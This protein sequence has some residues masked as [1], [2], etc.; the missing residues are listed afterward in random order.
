MGINAAIVSR[1]WHALGEGACPPPSA[2][3]VLDGRVMAM[4]ERRHRHAEWLKFL[5]KIDQETPKDN[6]PHLIANNY[7]TRKRPVVQQ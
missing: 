3:N 4:R 2:L 1:H 5:R 6:A 7:D